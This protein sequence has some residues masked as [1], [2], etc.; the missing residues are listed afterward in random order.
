MAD[1]KTAVRECDEA[2]I[3]RLKIAMLA[4]ISR[5]TV[6]GTLREGQP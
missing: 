1:L 6:Y 2:G 3:P 5:Q 4:G